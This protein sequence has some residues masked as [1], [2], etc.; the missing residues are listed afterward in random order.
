M[1][2]HQSRPTG[3]APFP[4]ANVVS[5][6]KNPMVFLEVNATSFNNSGRDRGH[7]HC[8]G[9]VVVIPGIVMVIRINP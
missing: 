6:E 3:F 2:N 7:G 9:V 8:R 4:K 5:N 1:K